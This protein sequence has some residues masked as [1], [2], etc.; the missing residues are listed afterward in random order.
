MDKIELILADI[1]LSLNDKE[2]GIFHFKSADISTS[3]ADN[4]EKWFKIVEK[5]AFI[6]EIKEHFKHTISVIFLSEGDGRSADPAQYNY[7]L[8]YM[9][10]K[11]EH[12]CQ[13]DVLELFSSISHPLGI[14]A[15]V[16]L[17]DNKNYIEEVLEK[18]NDAKYFSAKAF[19]K[20]LSLNVNLPE[21]FYDLS[22]KDYKELFSA[23]KLQTADIAQNVLDYTNPEKTNLI[24]QFSF[25]LELLAVSWQHNSFLP[26]EFYKHFSE[27][28]YEISR[29]LL[30]NLYRPE[31]LECDDVF[32]TLPSLHRFAIYFV[33]AID[34]ETPE[35]KR[36]YLLKALEQKED[37]AL[38]INYSIE[39]L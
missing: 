16:L 32:C 4:F 27:R 7:V 14:S 8:S 1:Y 10:K 22:S 37:M 13:P 5:N 24:P 18:L 34:S 17:S 12:D 35:E 33:I 21:V 11:L 29:I 20:L 2:N 15:K 26:T 6:P 36:L 28:F 9:H 30:T 31:I 19:N 39:N 25:A 3:S 23:V 38:L